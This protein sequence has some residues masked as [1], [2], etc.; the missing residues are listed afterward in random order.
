[1]CSAGAEYFGVGDM[2]LSHLCGATWVL[3]IGIMIMKKRGG[4]DDSPIT[5]NTLKPKYVFFT[6][7]R[8]N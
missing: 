3:A 2:C 5:L 1:M 7:R 8:M 4:R 6:K